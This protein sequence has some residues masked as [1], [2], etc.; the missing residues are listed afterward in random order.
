M[1]A[2]GGGP[3]RPTPSRMV[4]SEHGRHARRWSRST[5][6]RGRVHGVRLAPCSADPRHP[7]I[8]YDRINTERGRPPCAWWSPVWRGPSAGVHRT[9]PAQDRLAARLVCGAAHDVWGGESFRW[10]PSARRNNIHPQWHT[11]VPPTAHRSVVL[12]FSDLP[13]PDGGCYAPRRTSNLP[14]SGRL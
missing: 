9:A 7:M 10:H 2:S 4:P 3:H 5:A 8:A 11:L 14:L 12:F 1:I 13:F 6:G